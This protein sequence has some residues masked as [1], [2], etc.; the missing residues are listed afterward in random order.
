MSGATGEL[1]DD[2]S[3]QNDLHI[4]HLHI[5]LGQVYAETNRVPEAILE[6]KQGLTGDENGS[7]HYQLARLYQKTG[8]TK[9]AAETF[10]AS[11]RLRK[12]WDDRASVVLQQSA[13]DL[14]HQ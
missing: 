8:D 14:K 7:I 9:T 3:V 1:V 10:Q 12:Q 13:T 4:P 5:L 6:Y 2:C 11:Q